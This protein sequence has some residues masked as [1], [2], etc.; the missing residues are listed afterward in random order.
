MCVTNEL[1]LHR[2]CKRKG[3]DQKE[4][5]EKRGKNKQQQ[6]IKGTSPWTNV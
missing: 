1:G 3:R 2:K 4:S 5:G 6:T